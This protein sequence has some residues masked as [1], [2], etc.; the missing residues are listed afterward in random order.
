MSS[1][2]VT[3]INTRLQPGGGGVPALEQNPLQRAMRDIGAGGDFP[4][5]ILGWTIGANEF[6]TTDGRG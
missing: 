6:L 5:F 1:I 3:L 4:V 2:S